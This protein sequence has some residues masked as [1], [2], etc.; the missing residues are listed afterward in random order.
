MEFRLRRNGT[1]SVN[2]VDKEMEVNIPLVSSRSDLLLDN[3]VSTI[4]LNELYLKERDKCDNYRIMLTLHPY[5]TN[6][7]FNTCSEIVKNEGSNDVEHVTM[8]SNLTINK[9]VMGKKNSLNTYHMIRNTEYSKEDIGYEYHPG[10]DIFNNHIIRNKSYRI[11]NYSKNNKNVDNFNTIEDKFR[12]SDGTVL[13]KCCRKDINDDV[14]E[15]KSL[16]NIED[17]LSFKNGEAITENLKEQNGWFGF[18]N[19]TTIEAKDNKGNKLD[20]NRVINNKSNCEFI[21]M[22]PDRT[23]FSFAP[24]YN[25]FKFRSE[26]N[27]D[28]LLTYPFKSVVKDD[29]GNDLNV[30][31]DGTCNALY[32]VDT[33]YVRTASGNKSMMFRTLTKHNLQI[34]DYVKIY[35]NENETGTEWVKIEK[36]FRVYS[37]GNT[38]GDYKDYYFHIVD[39]ELLESIFCT[40]KENE[41][42]TSWDYVRD[43]FYNELDLT[44]V[45]VW[46]SNATYYLNSLVKKDGKI[47]ICRR[48]PIGVYSF[49]ECFIL[50]EGAISHYDSN[51]G[52]T[53]FPSEND[54][55]IKV[56][57][58]YY[59][60]YNHDI[61]KSYS[62]EV[63]NGVDVSTFIMGIVNNALR[64]DDY[65]T[66]PHPN[67]GQTPWHDYINFRFVKCDGDTECCYYVRKFKSI[68]DDKI[69]NELY[70]L[71]FAN[72]VYGDEIAQITYTDNINVNHLRDNKGYPLTNIYAT[73]IKSNRGYKEWYKHN[74][75]KNNDVIEYS[76]C[77]GPVTCGFDY[78][79]LA[80]DNFEIRDKRK[81]LKDVRF[82]SNE[83]KQDDDGVNCKLTSI[84]NNEITCDSLEFYGDVVE[85]NP[86]KCLET[87]LCDVNFRFNTAQRELKESDDYYLKYDEMVT[88]DYM[89]TDNTISH[90]EVKEIKNIY[91]SEGYY[92]KPHFRIP[93]KGLSN[94]QQAS[95]RSLFVVNATPYQN[96][97][98][99][100][101]I[102]TM[103]QHLLS[104]G[105]DLLITNLVG[106]CEHKTQVVHVFDKYNFLIN[107]ISRD[108]VNYHDWV[109]T[110]TSINDGSMKV[111]VVNS[112]IPSYVN[113]INNGTY[114]W[115]D[116][117][118]LWDNSN[119]LSDK[120][121]LVYANNALY[122]D[123][124]IN[125]FL[126]RQNYDNSITE[127][128]QNVD[129]IIKDI[130]GKKN[131][132]SN[133]YEYKQESD[134]QC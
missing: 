61:N 38:K 127:F 115:R 114:L 105:D 124:S 72:T 86:I 63:K 3:S 121:E 81:K 132:E 50:L 17:I 14:L 45:D 99:F 88:D 129:D 39:E 42:Y 71:A 47:F 122:I 97:G 22:Y 58:T 46:D 49:D 36:K 126:K 103:N 35:Y 34:G 66:L 134:Y 108:D 95:H 79:S 131:L 112:V 7:L 69:N 96:N 62:D 28:I 98:M 120:G 59:T 57:E 56:D 8:D 33:K 113:K 48:L 43:Y 74:N 78:F 107:I 102:T 91:K 76:H 26:Y 110:C 85:Y 70:K 44:N 93:L 65:E 109:T 30:I 100:I 11:V 25:N 68:S 64:N 101:K 32:I 41:Q 111:K 16:Y 20:I 82:I 51:I 1:T 18:Y 31:Q 89:T 54:C 9:N 125:L 24:K 77:F 84:S 37:I 52:L 29:D 53:D 73:I 80:K 15:E 5:C 23:L 40:P 118:N 128:N 94:I 10:L 116:V 2:S 92:Y 133:N 90:I 60:L 13:K 75:E 87:V 4:N 104:I 117:V 55:Y 19:T 6:V 123:N 21:D 119:I 130:D 83:L 106:N 27:W 67:E 12:L